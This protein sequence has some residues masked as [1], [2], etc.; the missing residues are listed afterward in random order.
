[1]KVTGS[2]RSSSPGHLGTPL[3]ALGADDSNADGV[4]AEKHGTY[5]PRSPKIWTGPLTLGPSP[6]GGEGGGKISRFRFGKSTEYFI[7]LYCFGGV[8][9]VL[10]GLA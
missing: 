1:V 6:A 9:A 4:Q 10:G 8:A 5:V 3:T 7:W 2:L